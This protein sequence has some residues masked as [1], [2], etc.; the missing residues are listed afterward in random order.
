MSIRN[1]R[2]AVSSCYLLWVWLQLIKTTFITIERKSVKGTVTEIVMVTA[3]I[4][5]S[6]TC[7][8]ARAHN[9]TYRQRHKTV[10]HYFSRACVVLE[11]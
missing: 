6:R 11:A 9:R 1:C 2:E 5:G 3:V 7:Y 8:S 4:Y 10:Y